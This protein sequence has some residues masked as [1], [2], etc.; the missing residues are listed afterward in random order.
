VVGSCKY[1]D[2]PVGSG[3]M[4]LVSYSLRSKRHS[5]YTSS[6]CFFTVQRQNC[7]ATTEQNLIQS[8]CLSVKC[9]RM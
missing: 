9:N 3:A 1:D 6:Y 8:A 5:N 2:E 7:C 4:D